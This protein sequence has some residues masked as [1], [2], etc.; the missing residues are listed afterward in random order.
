MSDITILIPMAPPS[1]LLPNRRHRRGGFHP[2][3]A[4][5]NTSRTLAKYAAM[6]AATRTH[7]ITGPV[8]VTIHIGY[9][10]K[11]LLPDLDGSIS[12]TKPFW[13][14]IVDAG[15]LVDDDQIVKIIATHEKLKGKRG[16]KPEGF[17]R[18]TITALAQE[19]IA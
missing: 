14:G 7:P 9:G 18:M 19:N 4:A 15:L 12:A 10:H 2:G 11:R 5:A 13:D 6:N 16:T 17:T 1:E 8:S 3:I